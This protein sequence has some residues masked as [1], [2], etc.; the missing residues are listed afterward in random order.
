MKTAVVEPAAITD[1]LGS[2]EIG[3]GDVALVHG[4]ALI[5]A[6]FPAMPG[7]Q[8]LD[9]L[10][11]SIEAALHSEGTLLMPAF[12]PG[13][14]KGEPFDPLRTAGVGGMVA[15]HFRARSGVRRSLDP[16][17]SFAIKGALAQTLCALPA[18]ECFGPQSVFAALHEFNAH[19]VW[20]GCPMSNGGTFIHYVEKSHGV[21]YRYDKV[22]SGTITHRDGQSSSCSVVYYV[23]DLA[24][25]SEVDLRRLH[26]RLDAEGKLKSGV[27]GRVRVLAARAA[28]LFNT[29]SKMLDEDPVSLIAEGA[30][31]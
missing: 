5:A 22:F 23:R 1:V 27:V 9:L 8:R 13:F 12:S 28:E 7:M 2:M 10:I 11:A 4:D 21:D 17:F 3:A 30:R 25:K 14:T 19:I 18:K 20:L 24:R 26:H 15:E 16:I 29:A 31:S 6:Q